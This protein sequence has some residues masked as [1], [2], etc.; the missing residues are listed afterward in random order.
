[1]G[2]SKWTTILTFDVMCEDQSDS[3]YYRDALAVLWVNHEIFNA[4]QNLAFVLS[5][6]FYG[7]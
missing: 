5:E 3:S 6:T 4:F 1:M 2:K 7:I